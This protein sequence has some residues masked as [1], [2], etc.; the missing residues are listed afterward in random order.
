M[1]RSLRCAGLP[2]ILAATCAVAVS[3]AARGVPLKVTAA[4]SSK[5]G[6]FSVA[7][8]DPLR[9]FTGSCDRISTVGIEGCQARQVLA[10]DRQID[11]VAAKILAADRSAE[12]VPGAA[13]SAAAATADLSA[14][15]RSWLA[16][17]KAD[18]SSW[19]DPSA[20]G[21][22]IGILFGECA[23]ADGKA[24][25]AELR[26]QLRAAQCGDSGCAARTDTRRSGRAPPPV[27]LVSGMMSANAGLR[28]APLKTRLLGPQ[29][30]GAT[31]R[32]TRQLPRTAEA[33]RGVMPSRQVTCHPQRERH[34]RQRRVKAA[35]GHEH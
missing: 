25:L 22:I 5:P 33:A 35:R 16:F 9:N 13:L 28:I 1:S 23:V 6:P 14:A 17:R 4:V 26:R 19:S 29:T 12:S 30:V 27:H 24:R 15:Q 32:L 21:T 11:G 8:H 3:A 2:I 34:D 20:G 31:P 18:C 10:V 7:A